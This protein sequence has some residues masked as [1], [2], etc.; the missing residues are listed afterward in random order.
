MI[1]EEDITIYDSSIGFEN[2]KE[3][4]LEITS[5]NID[6]LLGFRKE[7]LDNQKLRE[8]IVD[9][10]D[11]W[12]GVESQRYGDHLQAILNELGIKD[13]PKF[14][15]HP[16]KELIDEISKERSKERKK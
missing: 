9:L 4:R 2:G 1:N 10:A 7:I 3:F 12:D 13:I 6:E 15:G 8:H 16:M 5:T 11:L 14:Y